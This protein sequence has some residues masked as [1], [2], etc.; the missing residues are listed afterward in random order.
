ML[1]QLPSGGTIRIDPSRYL[2]LSDEE[3]DRML[4]YKTGAEINDPFHD[5]ALHSPTVRDSDYPEDF[6]ED[7]IPLSDFDLPDDLKEEL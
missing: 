4:L 3:F 5:S 1:Y 2:S 7:L 6:D